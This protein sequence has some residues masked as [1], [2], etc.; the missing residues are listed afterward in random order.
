MPTAKSEPMTYL[1]YTKI[2]IAIVKKMSYELMT[3]L[4]DYL[5]VDRSLLFVCKEWYMW[6]RELPFSIVDPERIDNIP[7]KWIVIFKQNYMKCS[8]RISKLLALGYDVRIETSKNDPRIYNIPDLKI[9]YVTRCDVDITDP[10]NKYLTI[11]GNRNHYSWCAPNISITCPDIKYERLTLLS[12]C[13]WFYDN[14]SAKKIFLNSCDVDSSM[15]YVSTVCDELYVID[16]TYVPKI[17]CDK[18]ILFG[19]FDTRKVKTPHVVIRPEDLRTPPTDTNNRDIYL[20]ELVD[21]CNRTI[22]VVLTMKEVKKI[23]VIYLSDDFYTNELSRIANRIGDI[24]F[25]IKQSLTPVI[26][27]DVL[28]DGNFLNSSEEIYLSF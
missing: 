18:M 7:H 24:K 10:I 22:D 27:S 11:G 6:C 19:C 16:W 1:D 21:L 12:G 28:I 4:V 2:D 3:I 25:T 23:D 15:D 9:T 8:Y 17:V 14:I 26:D 13:F 5:R 20:S